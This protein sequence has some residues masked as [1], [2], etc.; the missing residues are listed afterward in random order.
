MALLD[1]RI[2]DPADLH[3]LRRIQGNRDNV[4]AVQIGAYHAAANGVA[5]DA[6]EQIEQ[7]GTVTDTDALFVGHGAEQFL[8]EVER[9][10]DTL[11]KAE[12]RVWFQVGGR[13]RCPSGEGM[14]CPEKDVRFCVHQGVEFQVVFLQHGTDHLFVKAAD[15]QNADLAV[16]VAHIL[17]DLVGACLPE[18][19]LVGLRGQPLDEP[20]KSVHRK[21]IVLG[22]NGTPLACLLG[23]AVV[24]VEQVCLFHHL[25]GVGQE[26]PSVLGEGDP[27][28]GAVE[29][30]DAE[31]LFQG[32]DSTGKRGLRHIELFCRFADRAVFHNGDHILQ[33]L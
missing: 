23:C 24:P 20:D 30:D 29:N 32:A 19:E 33:L 6:S 4:A 9:V 5:V 18:G 22:G 26:L 25:S 7:G 8:C 12:E 13:D 15:V 1:S 27:S 28:G 11:F 31:F 14:L 3:P 21:G 16:E 10:V 17:H 2:G